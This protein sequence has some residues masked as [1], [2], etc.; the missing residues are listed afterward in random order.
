MR[1]IWET[2]NELEHQGSSK[3][4]WFA[5]GHGKKPLV[6][7]PC[8]STQGKNKE[9]SLVSKDPV[10]LFITNMQLPLWKVVFKVLNS[11]SIRNLMWVHKCL[12]KQRRI[13]L[14]D[15][16]SWM[17]TLPCRHHFEHGW[18]L[19]IWGCAAREVERAHGLI[20]FSF[21]VSL[22]PQS[23]SWMAGQAL[24]GPSE[25]TKKRMWCWNQEKDVKP[26]CIDFVGGMMQTIIQLH[27]RLLIRVELTQVKISR[28]SH[29]I[30]SRESQVTVCVE[31]SWVFG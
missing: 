26:L 30:F 16:I 18:F 12:W 22:E 2:S 29:V 27:F 24:E 21:Y 8:R 5:P 17:L 28:K 13:L 14:S 31:S 6:F 23:L 9:G 4:I 7:P 19:P 1:D 20:S 10:F 11:F 25:H 3:L 15:N